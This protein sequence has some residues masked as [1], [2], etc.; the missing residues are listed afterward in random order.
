[1][2]LYKKSCCNVLALSVSVSKTFMRYMFVKSWVLEM[3]GR[4]SNNVHPSSCPLDT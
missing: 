2:C 4:S 1:M 3:G